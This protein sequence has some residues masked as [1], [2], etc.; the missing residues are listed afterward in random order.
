MDVLRGSSARLLSLVA[1]L[2]MA[3]AYTS[4]DSDGDVDAADAA[5]A[6]AS[7]SS[8][9]SSSSSSGVMESDL[10]AS[11][12]LMESSI[13]GVHSKLDF[14]TQENTRLGQQLT[15][16][17]HRNR[18]LQGDLIESAG[19]VTRLQ[20]KIASDGAIVLQYLAG[21]LKS[22][23]LTLT[24]TPEQS[25]D[26]IA[27]LSTL[28]TE[29]DTIMS[30]RHDLSLKVEELLVNWNNEKALSAQKTAE[31][32]Q[33]KSEHSEEL[34]AA[35]SNN[36][37]INAL[38]QS[39]AATATENNLLRQRIEELVDVNNKELLIQHQGLSAQLQEKSD[40]IEAIKEEVQATVASYK[41]DI[42]DLTLAAAESEKEKISL[43][44]QLTSRDTELAE[45]GYVYVCMHEQYV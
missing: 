9:S 32:E 18:V 17:Q 15:D 41:K 19:Q 20:E 8:S 40:S 10:D 26:V 33:M 25:D 45:K 27:L 37:D 3:D 24:S 11:I 13:R 39:L 1:K 5:A 6:I 16:E 29:I 38:S 2:Q 30:S 21:M 31:I 34:A 7:R 42:H 36:A 28:Q 22:V 35:T 23:D 4:T 43:R 44:E 14:M 12:D